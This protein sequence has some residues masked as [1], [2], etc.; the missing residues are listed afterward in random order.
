MKPLRVAFD[1]GGVITKYTSQ[2]RAL[3]QALLAAGHEVLVITDMHDK[4]EVLS[5]L[6]LNDFGFVT[7]SNV[8][9]ADW[10]QYGEACK[11]V[12]CGRLSVDIL[13]DDFIGYVSVPGK[14]VMRLL[15]MPDPY[16]PYWSE[17]WKTLPGQEPFGRTTKL[18]EKTMEDLLKG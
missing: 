2:V 3:M 4:A 5:M 16:Y 6:A 1:I 8:Y 10:K 12:L 9:C 15:V 13:Y 11:A 14:P 7:E 18:D 17:T